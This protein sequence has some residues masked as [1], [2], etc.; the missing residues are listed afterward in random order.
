MRNGFYALDLQRGKEYKVEDDK[1]IP[2]DFD[3]TGVA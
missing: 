2:I 3:N 1:I